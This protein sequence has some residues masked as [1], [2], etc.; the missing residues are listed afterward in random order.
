MVGLWA[1]NSE[2]L[3]RNWRTVSQR[4]AALLRFE[5]PV[6]AVFGDLQAERRLSAAALADPADDAA[7][8]AQQRHLTDASVAGLQVPAGS[9][10]ADMGNGIKQIDQ[11]LAHLPEYRSAVDQRTASQQQI[12]D[13]Y[14]ALVA[15]DLELFND[16][17][18]VGLADL[19]YRVRPVM[20]SIWGMEMLARQDTVLTPGIVS[21]VLNRAERTQL[22]QLSGAE[23]F[24]YDD[25][26]VPLLPAT[27]ATRYRNV[28]VGGPWQ[29]KTQVEQAVFSAPEAADGTTKMPA[30]IAGQWQ[31]SL[32]DI[33]PQLQNLN[34]VF[35]ATITKDTTA[36]VHKMAVNLITNSAL[37]A[38]AVVLV[39]ALTLVLTGVLRR[40]IFALRSAALELQDKLPSVVDRL[41][42][43]EIVDV[44]AELP[45]INY[46]ADE[47][48][49]L[50]R[51]LNAA[52]SS[53]LETTVRQVEQY[54][55]FERLLQRIARR[56]QLLI[57]L[58]M[59]RLTEMERRHEDPDLLEGLFD[60][61]HLTA[62]LRRYEENLVILGGGQ[63]QRRWRKP[64][65]LLDVLRSA[66]GE[67]Q[68]YRRIRIETEP[69]VL[70]SE[71]AVGAV[72]HI[73]AELMENAVAF[74]KPPTPV[75]V[76]ASRVTRGLAIEIEDRGMGMA[77]GQYAAANELM[78]APPR[79][80]VV[81]Q[82]DDARLGL[83]VVARLAAG[84]GVG[85]ELRP[86]PFGGTRAVVLVPLDLVLAAGREDAGAPLA[87][88]AD[89][90]QPPSAVDLPR[91]EADLV[92]HAAPVRVPHQAG[93]RPRQEP[94]AAPRP[95]LVDTDTDADTEP[96]PVGEPVL[97]PLPRRVRQASLAAE[98]RE[99]RPDGGNRQREPDW[100]VPPARH[101]P[102]RSGA[103][104]G[105]FQ[106]QS[107]L[108]RRTVDDEH[109][110]IHPVPDRVPAPEE[111]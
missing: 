15:T 56:T 7:K 17:S 57:G 5:T 94:P 11:G 43:G 108:A 46:G 89:A 64:V 79:M 105:A 22:A 58:Q 100:Q 2:Q 82:A 20:D 66:Q 70:I 63:P 104:I 24:I 42:R 36:E 97:E 69:D 1:L 28:L 39:I 37:G 49:M 41:R 44:D 6:L 78:L 106:R 90:V 67:V 16:S 103:S 54:R 109:P 61:D 87:A 73:L 55:G 62:R 91:V 102:S 13:D 14:T 84:L 92:E 19:N 45:E 74:S 107:R 33:T 38:A 76:T 48:G 3:Y 81:S 23:Q 10:L 40:R 101:E 75:E 68:D 12:Y 86:S 9:T 32:A 53:A 99:A 72:V 30:G 111:D 31:Q 85:V 83:Y 110:S 34:Q 25:K 98:L 50:G 51:A 47:L 27:V 4:N 65:L 60:L 96:G 95:V 52:R 8:L 93:S 88:M 29:Q 35:G 59:K 21:G 18:N 71:R 77:E 26:V 80:D